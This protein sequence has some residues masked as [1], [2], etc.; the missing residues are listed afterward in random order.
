[1]PQLN[2]YNYLNMTTWLIIIYIYYH[3]Y[4]KQFILPS[5]YEYLFLLKK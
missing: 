4:M 5:I 2:Y 3:I 1:M